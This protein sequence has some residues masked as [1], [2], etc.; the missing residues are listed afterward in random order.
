MTFDGSD[1][2]FARRHA[3]KSGKAALSCFRHHPIGKGFEI[4]AGAEV[5]TFACE[6]PDFETVVRVQSVEGVGQR[7]GHLAIDGILQ[8]R[9][10]ESNDQHAP[11][12]L[13]SERG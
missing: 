12:F 9:S 1:Q 7:L 5:G 6:N 2:R 10:S 13:A 8:L 3:R 11:D 4:H